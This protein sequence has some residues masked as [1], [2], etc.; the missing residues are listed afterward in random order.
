[1]PGIGLEMFYFEHFENTK[2]FGMDGETNDHVQSIKGRF[3]DVKTK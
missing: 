3:R 1:M 2:Q